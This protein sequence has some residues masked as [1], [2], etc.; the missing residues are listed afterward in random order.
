MNLAVLERFQ[1]HKM[2]DNEP[3]RPK[4]FLKEAPKP[5]KR[6]CDYGLEI[7]VIHLETEVG[8]IEAYNRMVKAALVL[9][10]KIHANKSEGPNPMYA[11]GGFAKGNRP[12]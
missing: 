10:E 7:A 12:W 1:T 9:L 4:E 11:D 2:N 8:K 3:I 6:P 5:I